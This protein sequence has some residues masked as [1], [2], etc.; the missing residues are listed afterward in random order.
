MSTRN[1]DKARSGVEQKKKLLRRKRTQE[2][3]LALAA[4]AAAQKNVADTQPVA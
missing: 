2:L 4:A 3:R 1:G